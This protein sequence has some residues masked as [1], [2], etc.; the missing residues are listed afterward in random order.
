[1]SD[2][3]YVI[4]KETAA[5][6]TQ[7]KKPRSGKAPAG[8]TRVLAKTA[9]N[10]SSLFAP[11]ESS[12]DDDDDDE[13]DD[14]EQPD[15]DLQALFMCKQTDE[16]QPDR[17]AQQ[18]KEASEKELPP[19]RGAIKAMTRDRK[20]IGK[21]KL[22]VGHSP[23]FGTVK[24]CLF[25]HKSYILRYDTSTNKWP[26]VIQ[27]EGGEH[28]TVISKLWDVVLLASSKIVD[29]KCLTKDDLRDIRASLLNG[30]DP[31]QVE[32]LI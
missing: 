5:A 16:E 7:G 1:M 4:I 3:A 21:S 12:D 15:Q 20:K 31:A 26:L 22:P 2:A 28:Q 6:I 17:I 25:S 13:D 19:T 23:S 18:A 14:D 27:V 32:N 9:S 24:L 11:S 29:V 30:S 10:A 8:K